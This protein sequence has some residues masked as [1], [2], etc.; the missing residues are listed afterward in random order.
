M[1]TVEMV[2]E[3]RRRWP[4]TDRQPATVWATRMWAQVMAPSMLGDLLGIIGDWSPDVVIHDEGDYASPV[5]ASVA[6]IPWI[7]HGWGSPL[8]PEA[9]LV[10]VEDLTAAMWSSRGLDVPFAG[11]LYA[12]ALVNPCPPMLRRVSSTRPSGP[13]PAVACA[14]SSPHPIRTCDAGLN[15]SIPHW[16]PRTSSC[17]SHRWLPRAAW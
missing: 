6:G 3:R 2:A 17:R 4:D 15:R 11:G 16:S 8:R 10:E 9:E 7:T 5:A 12:H 1:S 14:S 13:A